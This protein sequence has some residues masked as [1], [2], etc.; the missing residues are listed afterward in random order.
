MRSVFNNITGA[1]LGIEKG[2]I[3]IDF[4]T[5][6]VEFV[7]KDDDVELE[8]NEDG[9]T[10]HCIK[11]HLDEMRELRDWLNKYLPKEDTK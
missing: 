6:R 3:N 4:K 8:E 10:I 2:S 9:Q 1:M 11:M 5:R 7:F